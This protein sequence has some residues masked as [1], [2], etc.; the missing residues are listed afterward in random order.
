M[1]TTRKFRLLRKLFWRWHRRVGIV[2]LAFLSI[3]AAT[4]IALNHADGMGLHGKSLPYFLSSLIYPSVSSESIYQYEFETSQIYQAGS[5]LYVQDQEL[6]PSCAEDVSGVALV[7][8][9]IWVACDQSLAVFQPDGLFIE[10][11][12]LTVDSIMGIAS[13]NQEICINQDGIWS[14]LNQNS[15][16]LTQLDVD[17]NP[18]QVLAEHLATPPE[19][20]IR[21]PTELNIG[22]LIADIHNGSVLGSFGRFLVDLSGYIIL[23]LAASGCYLWLGNKRK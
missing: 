11:I 23:F 20:L 22:R 13:C 5:Q 16:E 1:K 21:S 17:Q 15:L 9:L 12:N 7:G 19:Y 10:R 3:M 4:G 14:A 18:I 6:L 2:S 8:E